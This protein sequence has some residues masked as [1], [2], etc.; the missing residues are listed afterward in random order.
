MLA[1][2]SRIQNNEDYQKIISRDPEIEV[3]RLYGV[4]NIDID[5]RHWSWEKKYYLNI[6]GP[7]NPVSLKTVIDQGMIRKSDL[8]NHHYYWGICRNARVARWSVNLQKFEHLRFKAGWDIYTIE[9]PENI[10]ENGSEDKFLRFDVFVPWY[11]IE[12]IH[13]EKI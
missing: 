4:G 7:I 1:K 10:N 12:P 13:T 11:E 6:S 2:V 5:H 3:A 8:K 9:H